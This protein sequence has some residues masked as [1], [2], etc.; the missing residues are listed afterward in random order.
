MSEMRI[1]TPP[2][3]PVQL[4]QVT[5]PKPIATRRQE[6][7][8]RKNNF[9]KQL[10]EARGAEQE[11]V[12]REI[13]HTETKID[14]RA[15]GDNLSPTDQGDDDVDTTGD[16]YSTIDNELDSKLIPKKRF[17]KELEKRKVLED[18]LRRERD[19]RIKHETELTLYNKALDSINQQQSSIPQQAEIDPIDSDAHSYY[20]NKI[21]DLEGKFEKQRTAQSDSEVR[22][23]FANTVNY[24][25]AEIV[26]THP[27]WNE[28]YNFVLDVEA[29]KARMQGYN[30]A[31]AKEY[32]VQQL[33]PIAWQAYNK[34]ENVAE[35]AY[36]IAKAY[37]YKP[38]NAPVKSNIS[39]PNLDSI[40]R[41]MQKSHS[42]LDE[43]KGVSTAVAPEGAAYLSLEGFK[44][45]LT[46]KNGR[47]TN[48]DEFHKALDTF[49]KN[50][51]QY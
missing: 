19:L 35:V 6:A 46:G 39:S 8:E 42:L 32:A 17:D 10:D 23:Q 28:A 18:E 12:N 1:E 15:D 51:S 22:Q 16:G 27:D 5:Q 14:S 7:E 36:N 38:R 20:M 4:E 48:L 41:N 33:Q 50:T 21:R 47:G 13:R 34:G 40:D 43:V 9:Y 3:P 31:Q 2:P 49:R 25:A 24:Q 30:D 37:G 45:K 11:S 44:R 29:N 26:K